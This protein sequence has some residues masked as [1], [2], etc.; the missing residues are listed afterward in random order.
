LPR[1]GSL[2]DPPADHHSPANVLQFLV[3]KLIRVSP[4]SRAIIFPELI[5]HVPRLINHREASGI[6]EDAYALWCTAK[7]R[8][9]MMRQFWGKEMLLWSEC[10][11]AAFLRLHRGAIG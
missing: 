8:T 6:L 10:V 3:L 4:A 5:P 7:E 2:F 9:A 11:G 1:C